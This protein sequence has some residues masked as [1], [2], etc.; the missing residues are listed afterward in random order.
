MTACEGVPC[1]NLT[2][3]SGAEF[4]RDSAVVGSAAD[5]PEPDFGRDSVAVGPAADFPEPDFERIA[6]LLTRILIPGPAPRTGRPAK[7]TDV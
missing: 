1:G 4:G 2:A 3:R 5:F 7:R 6:L